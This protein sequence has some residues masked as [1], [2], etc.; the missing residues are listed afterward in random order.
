VYVAVAD[1]NMLGEMPPGGFDV[2]VVAMD[3]IICD[4]SDAATMVNFT[5]EGGKEEEGGE[6]DGEETR[7]RTRDY[8]LMI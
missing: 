6:D 1:P 4:G 5:E 8:C 7:A 2:V 3:D